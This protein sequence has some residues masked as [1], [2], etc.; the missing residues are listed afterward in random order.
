MKIEQA[1][2]DV[3]TMNKDVWLAICHRSIKL[4]SHEQ[5]VLALGWPGG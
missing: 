1:W 3:A 5:V 2:L 4:Y